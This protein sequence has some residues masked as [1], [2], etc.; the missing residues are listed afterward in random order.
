M[1]ERLFSASWHRVATLRPRLRAHTEVGRQ[2]YRGEVWYVLRDPSTDRFHRFGADAQ[3]VIGLMD[4]RRSVAEIWEQVADA[5]G[6][7]APTQDELIRLLGQLHAA[8]VLQCELSPDA[9]EL[10]DRFR[11]QQRQQ[12]LGR[13]LNPFAVRIHLFDPDRFLAHTLP[14]LRPLFG[15]VALLVW[16]AVVVPAAIGVASHWSELSENALDRLFTPTQMLTLWILFPMI[17]LF[18]ELGHGYAARAQGGEVHDMGVMFLVFNPVPYVDASC[19][20]SFPSKW[21]RAGVG[22]AGM[23]VELFLAALA[24]Y[25]WVSAEPGAVRAVAYNVL[26]IAG[27][28]TL[29]FNANPLLRFDG[30]YIA[31]DLLEIPNLR[32]RST[33]LVLY[34]W[35][36]LAFGVRESE[37]PRTAP[38]EAPWLVLYAVASLVYR[39]MIVVAILL[40]VLEWNLALGLILAAVTIA[41]GLGRTLYRGGRYL[42]TSPRLRYTRSRAVAVSATLVATAGVLLLALPLPLRTRAEGVVWMPEEALVRAGTD[43]FI[44]R[45]V[46]SPGSQVNA[47]DPLF[48]TSDPDLAAQLASARARVA[49]LE[50]RLQEAQ[51]EERSRARVA[52]EVLDYERQRLARLVERSGRLVVRAAIGGEFVVP[53]HRDLPGRHVQQGELLGYVLSLDTISVRAVVTQQEVDLVRERTRS[54]AVRLAERLEEVYPATILRTVPAA[55][56]RLPSPALGSVG[57]GQL[58]VDPRESRGDRSVES[59]FEVELDVAAGSLPANGGGRVYVQFDHGAEPLA[60]QWTRRLRQVFLSRLHV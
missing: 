50:V 14:L 28:T 3:R 31:S 44:E 39:A 47:G 60:W 56:E 29:I 57:G 59:L 45:V 11:K 1:R 8:D 46:A 12:A 18:H 49:E 10:F 35:E 55:N 6:D 32:S 21:R 38:G 19:S 24:F 58:P 34:L 51:V 41:G 53:R 7:S 5:L 43:G 15:R 40:F 27:T 4:G 23:L 20:W 9:A 37:A 13:L 33:A 16:L 54:V 36:R 22:A 2:R 48:E 52:A 42:L 26:L 30:Y 17:K 25:V